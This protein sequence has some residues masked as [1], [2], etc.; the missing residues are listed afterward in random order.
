[1]NSKEDFNKI[2]YSYS[3]NN[4]NLQDENRIL[5]QSIDHLK[6]E[7]NK[8]KENPLMVCEVNEILENLPKEGKKNILVICPGF[9]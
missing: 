3:S 8:F 4:S 1:M 6:K 9:S 2:V 5:K 7:I